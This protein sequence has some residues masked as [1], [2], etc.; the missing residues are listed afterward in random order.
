MS[1]PRIAITGMGLVSSIG[2]TPEDV[3]DAIDRAVSGL[4]PLR[5]FS[6]VRGASVPVGEV[7][8]DVAV[9][10]TLRQGS[11]T[12]HL[13]AYAAQYALED[14]G[15]EDLLSK[16]R[17][18]SGIVLGVCTGGM[19]D[20]EVFLSDMQQGRP[21]DFAKLR[22]HE[23]ASSVNLI[24]EFL[25]L[26]GYQATVSTACTSGAVAIATAMDALESG[27]A[28]IML[29]G[30][31]DSLTRLTLNG[32]LSLMIVASDGCRPFDAERAGMSLGEGSG[33]L[34]L[35][36]EEHAR[37]RGA[38][39]HAFLAGAGN[40][41]DACHPTAPAPDGEGMGRA[42]GLALSAASLRCD[43]IQY[44]NAHGTGTIDNDL[45]EARAILNVFGPNPPQVSSTKRFFGHTLAAAG[46]IEAIVSIMAL[47]RQRVPANLGLRRVDPGIGLTPVTETA[48][49]ALSA[50]MSNSMGFG[51]S[52]CALIFAHA[53]SN[54]K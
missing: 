53:G 22:Y 16:E 47:E 48:D 42:M 13:A 23:C 49:A 15:L 5:L 17:R 12:D 2:W 37:A 30:G 46:A 4:G 7:K 10:S 35:E 31:V 41:C 28:H 25:G 8:G 21:L 39:I 45:N 36:T 11:R 51:G 38:R 24:S 27:E 9:R 54:G 52:N 50:V 3:W 19:L 29:A 1:N 6:S 18:T 26:G 32:F 34:V 33:V 14:A 44:I 20:S 40:T 43:Q